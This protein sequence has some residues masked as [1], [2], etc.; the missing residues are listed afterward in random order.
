MTFQLEFSLEKAT[1]KTKILPKA[2]KIQ[3][4]NYFLIRIL[5]QKKQAPKP[6][7]YQKLEKSNFP[8]TFQLEF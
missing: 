5:I 7:S 1:T 3:F 2:R 6:R 4:S 8:I